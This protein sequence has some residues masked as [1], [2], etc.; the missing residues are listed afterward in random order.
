MQGA[1]IDDAMAAARAFAARRQPNQA[2]GVRL[3][4]P[5]ARDSRWRR[6]RTGRRSTRVLAAAPP[7]THGT[8]IYDA[9][10]AALGV[11][12]DAGISSGSI[13]LLSDGADGNSSV[14]PSQLGDGVPPGRRA[15]LRHRA[16][17]RRLRRR[18]ARRPR[19][20]GRRDLRRGERL[21]GPRRD[22]RRARAQARQ[23]VPRRVPLGGSARGARRGAG[24][25]GRPRRE[26]HGGLSGADVHRLPA[27]P[28]GTSSGPCWIR[29]TRP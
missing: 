13:V 14:S 22:L 2:L 29:A 16:P 8:R 15:R 27:G 6:R 23:P 9:T 19:D 12:H 7:L 28:A 4:Q 17:V 26:R 1:A 11:L 3:L 24:C 10:H 20:P 5:H 21:Q 18:R 25:G